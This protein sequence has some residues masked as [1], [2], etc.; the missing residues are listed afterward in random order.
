MQ[1][2]NKKLWITLSVI[3]ILI[4]IATWI[5]NFIFEYGYG[6]WVLTFFINPLGILC[7]YLGSSRIAMISNIIMTLSFF[8]LMFFGSLIEA[9]F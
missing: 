7:G 6:Y 2:N 9:F 8:I 1:H 5:P 4:G 3:C